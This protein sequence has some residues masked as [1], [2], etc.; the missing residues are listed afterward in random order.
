VTRS[1]IPNSMPRSRSHVG[2]TGPRSVRQAGWVSAFSS[3]RFR[4]CMTQI[5]TGKALLRTEP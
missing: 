5:R 1:G 4:S 3:S 2:G